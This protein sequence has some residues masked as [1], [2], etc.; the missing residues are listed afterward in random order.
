MFCLSYAE[1][2]YPGSYRGWLCLSKYKRWSNP[3][4]NSF[5][6]PVLVFLGRSGAVHG[7]DLMALLQDRT[8]HNIRSINVVGLL[9]KAKTKFTFSFVYK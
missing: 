1:G 5:L 2:H 6:L 7:L 4:L 3:L 8:Y 9:K